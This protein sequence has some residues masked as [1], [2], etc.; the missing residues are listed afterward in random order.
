MAIEA[1]RGPPR[2]LVSRAPSISRE[3]P[4]VPGVLPSKEQAMGNDT[5]SET[6]NEGGE[7]LSAGSG[8]AGR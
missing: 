5:E 4:P 1:L 7:T 8:A 6:V 3:T 2:N